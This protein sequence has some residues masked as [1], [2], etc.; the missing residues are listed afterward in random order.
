MI[1]KMGRMSRNLKGQKIEKFR[2]NKLDRNFV[3]DEMK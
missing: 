1:D 3:I 2:P